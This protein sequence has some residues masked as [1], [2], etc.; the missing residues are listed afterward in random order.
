MMRITM[1]FTQL[2]FGKSI[3]PLEEI[4]NVPTYLTKSWIVSLWG[5]MTHSNL[6]IYTN[7]QLLQELQRERD[8]Y[9]MYGMRNEYDH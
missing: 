5:Y 7:I 1:I 3:L 4:D 2:E 9:I 6:S 8:T